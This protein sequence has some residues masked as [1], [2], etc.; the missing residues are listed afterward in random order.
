MTMRLR[1]WTKYG[2][3]AGAVLVLVT[4]FLLATGWG[5]AVAAQVTSVFVNNDSAHPVPVH[6]QGTARV[7]VV[8][9][10]SEQPM[11]FTGGIDID[12]GPLVSNVPTGKV[13]IA[14]YVT[15]QETLPS[16]DDFWD[17]AWHH[18]PLGRIGGIPMTP[19]DNPNN[20]AALFY[21]GSEQVFIPVQSGQG[22]RVLCDHAAGGEASVGGYYAP[23]PS[24]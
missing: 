3:G 16:S 10:P 13:F 20:T 24:G 22:L 4:A 1:R 6:E 8:G 12:S 14:T 2:T 21:V 11:L 17:C 15:V 19:E 7:S 18:N 5:S 9:D 23:A